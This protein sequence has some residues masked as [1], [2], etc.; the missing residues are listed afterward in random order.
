MLALALAVALCPA[1]LQALGAS[2]W[3]WRTATQPYT[4]DDIPRVERP[5][6]LRPS[7]SAQRVKRMREEAARF[8][9]CLDSLHDTSVDA[10][11][12]GSAI[13]RVR[14]ELDLNRRWQ[15]DP[16]F[17]AE[18]A[19]TPVL[20]VL[21]REGGVD[22]QELLSR[23]KN[24]P[25]ILEDARRNLTD[26]VPAFARLAIASLQGIRARLETLP[27]H[28]GSVAAAAASLE[29]YGAWLEERLPSMRSQ[30]SVGRPAYEEFL[31]T[32]A[33]MPFRPEDLLA[34]ARQE[35]ERCVAAEALEARRNQ[36]HPELRL[37]PDILAQTAVYERDENAIRVFL[38]QR[39]ILT[40]PDTVGHYRVRPIPPSV[41]ALGDFG[42]QDDFLSHDGV[43][44]LYPP[45]EKLGYFGR[46]NARDPR[47]NITHEGVPGHFFQL[48][49][50][51][52]HPDPMRRQ[53]YDSGANE[54][55]GFYAEEMMMQAGLYD[56]SPRT[57]EIVWAMARLR[58]ARVHVD[59][60]LALGEMTLDE[61]A[62]YL[63]RRA[64]MDVR[65]AHAEAA[66][67]SVNPGQAMTYQVGKLQILALLS[68]ARFA[69]GDRFELRRFHDALWLN[70]NVPIALLR[71]ELVAPARTLAPP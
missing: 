55:L 38:E 59:V 45:S 32:V 46:A 15:R 43:R 28:D 63:A 69:Q 12:L 64:P 22:G 49:R 21:V 10:R 33:L 44:W 36:G 65:T 47:P 52:A 31:H 35:W 19:L 60:K 61:A 37:F 9:K 1:N 48:S 7:W 14:W 34:M 17:Y 58:A 42:E 54:G 30:G 53:Y 2:F 4:T 25:A 50:S 70:G 67:F 18:Q 68:E 5:R 66:S 23:V 6:G 3:E 11:L 16:T 24:V 29:A 27:E 26:A 13:A 39:N 62:E 71:E 57:R 8:R 51:R 56:Q 41:D 40:V 20:E